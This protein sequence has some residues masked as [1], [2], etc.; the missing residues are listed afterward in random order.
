MYLY[1][2]LFKFNYLNF[3]NDSG[4]SSTPEKPNDAGDIVTIRETEFF[5][6]F[7]NRF[8]K[9]TPPLSNLFGN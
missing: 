1:I 9:K 2:I 5:N 8:F 4:N 7:A 6:I 3:F